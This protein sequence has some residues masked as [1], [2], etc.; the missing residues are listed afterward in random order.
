MIVRSQ[1]PIRYHGALHDDVGNMVNDLIANE[2]REKV[3][4]RTPVAPGVAI[5]TGAGELSRTNGVRHIIHVAAVRGEL[6]AGYYQLGS[7]DRCVINAL[8]IAER[9]DEKTGAPRSIIFPLLGVGSGRG[10]RSATAF[11]MVCAAVD[12]LI[13]NPRSPIAS[14]CF[15]ARTN[16]TLSAFQAAI[17]RLPVLELKEI[18]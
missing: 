9:L 3:A 11:V 12:F 6:G 10:D 15:L 1:A 14:V 5:A 18:N 7:V 8:A 4:G 2:L 17:D 13:A 16:L